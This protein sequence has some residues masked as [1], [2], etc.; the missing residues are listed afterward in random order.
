M[1]LAACGGG[2]D[3]APPQP[4]HTTAEGI[5]TGTSPV[6]SLAGPAA[7]VLVLENG[8]TWGLVGLGSPL[9]ALRG[10]MSSVDGKISGSDVPAAPGTSY[11]GTY[12]PRDSIDARLGFSNFVGHYVS[13]YDQRASL[14]AFAGGRW[15]SGKGGLASPWFVTL[16]DSGT[17]R[18]IPAL[19]C[20]GNGS[21]KPRTSGKNVFDLQVSFSGEGCSDATLFRSESPRMS[22]AAWHDGTHLILMGLTPEP[23][24]VSQRHGELAVAVDTSEITPGPTPTPP[25][26]AQPLA[27]PTGLWTGTL[28]TGRTLTLLVLED[29][30]TWGHYRR[31]DGSLA[32]G[33]VLHGATSWADGKL[34][35]TGIEA[36]ILEGSYSGTYTPNGRMQMQLQEGAFVG[37][38]SSALNQAPSLA[39]IA[40]RYQGR[41]SLHVSDSGD[42]TLA[43][44]GCTGT[45]KAT[46]R[47]GSKNV[48]DFTTNIGLCYGNT[49]LMGARTGVMYYDNGTLTLM[50]RGSGPQPKGMVL[51][52]T[53][54]P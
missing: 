43:T 26:P 21:L 31:P 4:T 19:K 27:N 25:P 34:S 18:V 39:A 50:A 20:V 48:F 1:L 13:S 11:S 29:G 22:G 45:G 32:G 42:M 8:D 49:D 24:P 35:G 12:T 30:D 3:R 51:V 52:V 54:A 47:A 40:G 17:L 16:S 44:I 46:P 23:D 37:A 28:P 7:S 6:G 9:S 41:L 36:D 2:S 53:R 10:T 33:F 14:P 38:Y 15:A 5:W